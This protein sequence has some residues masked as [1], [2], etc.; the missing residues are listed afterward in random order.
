MVSFFSSLALIFIAELGDKTQ[1]LALSFAAKY[2][3][4]K[5]IFGV[6]IGTLVVHLFSVIIGEKLTSFIPEILL[7]IIIGLSF[8]GFGIWTLRGD[9]CDKEK[10]GFKKLG[11]VMT[12]AIAFFLAELG[13][14]TQLATISLAA[15][16]RSFI[17]VWL[18]S[19]LGMVVSDGIAVMVGVVA[20][21]KIPEKVIKY[22]SAAIF[23]LFGALIILEILKNKIVAG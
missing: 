3:P 4:A 12:V 13:D 11:P 21:K 7:K 14:K 22:I 23:I 5:V 15:E 10:Q 18:G 9:S 6:L 17:G 1:L 16:Y 8:V 2:K 20:G 19:S